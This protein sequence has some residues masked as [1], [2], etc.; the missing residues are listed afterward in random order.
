MEWSRIPL[1]PFSNNTT[2]SSRYYSSLPILKTAK[3]TCTLSAQNCKSPY[4]HA[5]LAV[6]LL[7]VIG[8]Q[9]SLQQCVGSLETSVFEVLQFTYLI[10]IP[11]SKHTHRP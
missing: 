7:D 10:R 1:K 11:F 3:E 8:C 9:K 2:S 6:G 4:L 5:A